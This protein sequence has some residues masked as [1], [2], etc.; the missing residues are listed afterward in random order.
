MQ[1]M[2]W[3]PCGQLIGPLSAMAFD[4]SKGHAALRRGRVSVPGSEYFLT[5]CT[6]GRRGGLAVKGIGDA[7]LEEAGAMGLDGTWILRCAIAMPD[8]LHL[9]IRLGERLPL[10]KTVQRLKAKTAGRLHAAG[11]EWERG[12][13]DRHL[14]PDDDLLALFLYVYLNPYRAGLC[15]R[16]DLWR[17][18]YCHPDDWTWFRGYL[19]AERPLPEWLM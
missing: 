19:D 7:I 6:E 13:F 5:I 1:A 15:A 4:S 11:L 9:V 10:A 17:W 16:S 8:H 18:Y 3:L 14:R 12:Y 2:P